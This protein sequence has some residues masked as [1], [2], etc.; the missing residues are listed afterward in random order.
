MGKTSRKKRPLDRST[1]CNRDA[2]LVIIATEGEKTEKQYFESTL[3]RSTRVQVKV[4]ETKAGESSP[5][6]VIRRLREFARAC[7]LNEG[8][9]LWL[10]V[11]RDHWQEKELTEVCAQARRIRGGKVGHLGI[12]NPCFE[13]WLFLH[14][15]DWNRSSVTCEEIESAL[16]KTLDGYNKSRL[17]PDDYEGLVEIAIER[18]ENLDTHPNGRWPENPGTHVYHLIRA[19]QQL[20]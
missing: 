12:S 18:A 8:D 10:V 19:I 2:S 5:S 3:F 13:L 20:E 4:L 15:A 11:D 16:R 17:N 14:H 6:H 7:E 1:G 9:Q